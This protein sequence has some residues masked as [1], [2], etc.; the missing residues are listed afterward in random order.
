MLEE[1]KRIGRK[2]AGRV[3][4][5]GII[6]AG[7]NDQS[8]IRVRGCS[9]VG[10]SLVKKLSATKFRN[11]CKERS[12]VRSHAGSAGVS[13]AHSWH[14]PQSVSSGNGAGG[15]PALP[16]HDLIRRHSS[17]HGMFAHFSTVSSIHKSNQWLRGPRAKSSCC[18]SP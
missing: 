5:V 13:P 15:T 11:G 7:S 8:G 6:I 9:W 17:Q 10:H 12:T 1:D 16:E 3:K 18:Y 14:T 2:E 4:H